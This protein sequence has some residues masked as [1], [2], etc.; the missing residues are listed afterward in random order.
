MKKQSKNF[1]SLRLWREQTTRLTQREFAAK[2]KMS[3]GTV[4]QIERGKMP[5]YNHVPR[6]A[7]AYGLTVEEFERLVQTSAAVPAKEGA[8]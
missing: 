5:R 2:A 7:E 4:S 8:A 1:T 3:Q 6:F